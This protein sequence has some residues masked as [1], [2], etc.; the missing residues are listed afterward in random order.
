MQTFLF[1]G[2]GHLVKNAYHIVSLIKHV[3]DIV[4]NTPHCDECSWI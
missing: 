1:K 2:E 3:S 4:Q